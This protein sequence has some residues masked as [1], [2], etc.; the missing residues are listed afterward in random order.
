MKSSRR[1]PR[2]IHDY[3]CDETRERAKTSA[4]VFAP[5]QDDE[6]LGCGGTVI[7]K[8]GPARR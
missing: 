2:K 7:L 6:T 4:I 1:Y 3:L 8:R 5:H